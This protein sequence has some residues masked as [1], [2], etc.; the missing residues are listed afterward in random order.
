MS[1]RSA[2]GKGAPALIR[3]ESLPPDELPILYAEDT[4]AGLA[5]SHAT[6]RPFTPGNKAAK[7]KRPALASSTGMALDAADPE[8]RRA[9]GWARRYRSARMRELRIQHGGYLSSGVVAMLVSSAMDLAAGRYLYALGAKTGDTD[10]LLKASKL[11]QSSRQQELTAMEIASREA[12]AIP[13][14]PVSPMEAIRARVA[15]MAE[16]EQQRPPEDVPL[17]ATVAAQGS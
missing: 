16:D 8:Y 10:I 5:E 6:G 11:Q 7:G 9:L 3:V 12:A 4:E 15:A 13:R 17:A 1:L 14:K 2:H